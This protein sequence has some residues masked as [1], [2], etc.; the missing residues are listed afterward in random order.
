MEKRWSLRQNLSAYNF[1]KLIDT[2]KL[3]D[4]G[5]RRLH[6]VCDIDKT[7][8]ETEFSGT[9]Q[10]IKIALEDADEKVT[11]RGAAEFLNTLR[12]RNPYSDAITENS[13]RPLHFVSASPPQLRRTL[14][15]K[16][17]LDGLDW[18]TDSFKNQA[19][20]LRKG[21]L[22]LLRHHVAFKTAT[23]LKLIDQ[24]ETSSKFI[25]IGDSA[26]FDG[27]IYLGLAAYLAGHLGDE[28][29][30]QF[31][32]IGGVGEEVAEDLQSVLSRNRKTTIQ[33]ILI[34]KVPHHEY[35]EAS[36][37]TDSIIPF[38]DYFQALCYMIAA[39]LIAIEALAPAVFDFHN[40]CGF[41]LGKILND[42]H[43]LYS[44]QPNPAIK[45]VIDDIEA[46]YYRVFRRHFEPQQT[47]PQRSCSAMNIS[48]EGPDLIAAAVKWTRLLTQDF[49]TK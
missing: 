38:E 33:A 1:R 28:D 49:A 10:M 46:R 47:L 27:Y 25:L 26:E 45:D 35:F 16:L 19:Y 3:E 8:L 36:P 4:T 29:Y 5:D 39:D 15:E 11:V 48:L 24:A 12:W 2:R 44:W 30:I 23:V 13:P 18:S 17:R 14:D 7:Y 6:I 20:N 22:D 37:L 9:L 40:R 41:S 43:A 42:L 32:K 31:L 21:R 34:R